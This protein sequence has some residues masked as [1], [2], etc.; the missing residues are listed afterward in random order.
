MPRELSDFQK[1]IKAQTIIRNMALDEELKNLDTKLNNLF[2]DAPPEVKEST[3]KVE[4]EEL[5]KGI[6]EGT[7]DNN[8]IARFLELSSKLGL[9]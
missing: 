3:S 2:S 6:R 5:I 9:S 8:R 7:A 1:K 4:M